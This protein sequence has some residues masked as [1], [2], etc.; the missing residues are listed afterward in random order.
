MLIDVTEVEVVGR[1]RLRLRF[2]DG[3]TGEID[4]SKLVDFRG[5]FSPLTDEKEFAQVRVNPEFGTIAWPCGADLDPD[6]LYAKVK[7]ESI[8]IGKRRRAS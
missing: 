1:H 8:E 7:G 4:V 2:A 5:V 3:V 6:V